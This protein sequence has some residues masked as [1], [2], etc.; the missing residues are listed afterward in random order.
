MYLN[1]FRL[2]SLTNAFKKNYIPFSA[3]EEAVRAPSANLADSSYQ[4][5]KAPEE[6]PAA[7]PQV[8]PIKAALYFDNADGFG[9]WR[10]L[11]SGRADR[12]LREARKKDTNLFRITLKKIKYLFLFAFDFCV[13]S[14]AESCRELSNGHFSDD[15]QKR[16]NG[17]DTVPIYEA[18]MTRDSRLVVGVVLLLADLPA[19]PHI[20]SS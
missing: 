17:T 7:Y 4:I 15:N 8:Q 2:E 16:L 14:N 1:F 13:L 9:Q 19:H 18:K 3:V 6:I 11:I 10:I 12:N 5:I 20:V